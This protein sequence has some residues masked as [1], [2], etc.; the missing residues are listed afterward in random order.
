MEERD[1]SNCLHCYEKG[2]ESICRKCVWFDDDNNELFWEP[3]E[4]ETN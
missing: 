2:P 4:E 3:E 1:C